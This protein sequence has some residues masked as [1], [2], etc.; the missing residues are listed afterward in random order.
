MRKSKA[1]AQ[2]ETTSSTPTRRKFLK[3]ATGVAAAGATL[4]E[5]ARLSNE[6]AGIVVGKFGPATVTVDEL[7]EERPK[8]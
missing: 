3:A 7:R 4:G 5:A 1:P 2:P 6:A 8:P